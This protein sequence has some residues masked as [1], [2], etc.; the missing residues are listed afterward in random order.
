MASFIL[1]DR[2]RESST[3]TGTGDFSLAGAVSGYQ[4][5]SAVCS[6]GDTFWY[7][8]VLSSSEWETGLGTYSASNTLTRTTVFES[9][10]AGAA[11]SFSAGTKDVFIDLPASK[12][13]V[14]FASDGS[15]GPWSTGDI[16]WTWKTTA[17]SGWIMVDDGTIGDASSSA[18]IRANADTAAL[19]AL[20]WNNFAN[21]EAAVST[22]RGANAAADY[23]AHKTIALPKALGRAIGVSG[24]GSGLTSRV[25]G[26]T[27]GEETHTPTLAE[28]FNHSHDITVKGT[29]GD[30]S[31]VRSSDGS[32][33]GTATTTSKGSSTPFNVMQPTAF[34][35]VM[36]KL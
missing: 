1:K 19:Y 7:A 13:K 31:T 20:I 27:A 32:N 36:V 28:M 2:V 6:T 35:N 17:D 29:G 3:T 12:A 24:A 18:S 4:R 9:S 5:F 15:L 8:I 33:S 14:L 25:L 21:A 16:K 34:W 23:A 30:A 11:V 10:N 22:G 26:K